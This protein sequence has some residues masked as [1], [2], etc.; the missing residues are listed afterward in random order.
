MGLLDNKMIDQKLNY[1][2][3][4]PVEDEIV[5]NPEDYKYSSAMNYAG[6]MGVLNIERI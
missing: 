1:I 5:I 2:H 4:N 3:N 6:E